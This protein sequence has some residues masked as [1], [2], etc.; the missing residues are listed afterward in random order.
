MAI[1]W[2]AQSPLTKSFFLVDAVTSNVT[3]IAVDPTTLK[4]TVKAHHHLGMNAAITDVAIGHREKYDLMY[5]LVPSYRAIRAFKIT[6]PGKFKFLQH[7]ERY[8]LPKDT[9]L[10]KGFNGQAVFWK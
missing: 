3:E 8:D 2:T 9:E 6:A 1:C 4:G 10:T 7:F 5:V